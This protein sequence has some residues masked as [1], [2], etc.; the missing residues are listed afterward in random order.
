MSPFVVLSIGADRTL[1]G[2]RDQVLRGAGYDVQECDL[3]RGCDVPVEVHF[4]I[5]IFCH[6]VRDEDKRRIIRAI[7]ASKPAVPVMLVRVNGAGS[8]LVDASVHSLD[9]PK[10]L[11]Q[12][13]R[14]LL[15][16]QPR[17]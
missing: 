15:A 3:S 12:C 6:T 7:R 1:L 8:E 17:S 11:I 5:V 9:G 4:D 10:V 13:V 14:E 16:T 2:L